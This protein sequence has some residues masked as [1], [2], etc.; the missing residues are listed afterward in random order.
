MNT[1][2]WLAFRGVVTAVTDF[3]MGQSEE[4]QG[5]YKV[6]IVQHQE[7]VVHFVVSPDTYIVNGAGLASGDTITGYYDGNAPVP[8][9]Y[10][11]RYQ[12]L[13]IVREEPDQQVK[14][15]F[16][17]EQLISRDGLLQLTLSS[18]TPILL[19]NGLDFTGYPGNHD[20]IVIYGPATKSIPART[21][22]YQV[23]VRCG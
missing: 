17:N 23:I 11:P 18:S 5:C 20:L 4:T 1:V 21:V 19:T 12:A 14:V 9:I 7:N 2:Q 22:P 13:V 10:P 6:I 8:L 16:F 15:D 3:P